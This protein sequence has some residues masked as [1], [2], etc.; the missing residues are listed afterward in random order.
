[1]MKDF[2]ENFKKTHFLLI[3]N[4]QSYMMRTPSTKAENEYIYI[5]LSDKF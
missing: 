1:M 2:E 5:Y 3:Y 4:G